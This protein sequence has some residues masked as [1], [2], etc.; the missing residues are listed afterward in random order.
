M[1][2][3]GV[4]THNHLSTCAAPG[5]RIQPHRGHLGEAGSKL[6][7]GSPIR[8]SLPGNVILSSLRESLWRG[9]ILRS[10]RRLRASQDLVEPNPSFSLG[11]D[12]PDRVAGKRGVSREACVRGAQH[13]EID[14]GA[15][16]P[17]LP[18]A[19][20]AE[21]VQVSSP[22]V[23]PRLKGSPAPPPAGV[24]SAS[25]IPATQ[26]TRDSEEGQRPTAPRAGGD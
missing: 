2:L 3:L 4:R 21:P 16:G 15:P 26:E 17:G 19:A 10:P 8:G 24:P 12:D 1:Q 23:F 14:G 6:G 22:G 20:A 9:S 11:N 7:P 18:H 5:L 25:V 13:G